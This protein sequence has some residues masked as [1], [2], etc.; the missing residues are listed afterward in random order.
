MVGSWVKATISADSTTIT[1]PLGQPIYYDAN[2][3]DTVVLGIMDLDEE[4]EE[5]FENTTVKE[6][7]YTVK[8]GKIS[9]N[10]TSRGRVLAALWKSTRAWAGQTDYN[11]Q[12]TLKTEAD[13]AVVAPEGLKTETYK[14][15]ARAYVGG[16]YVAYNVTVGFDGNDMYI[17]GLFSDTPDSWIKGTKNAAGSYVFT[18]GQ[19]LARTHTGTTNYYM[20]ATNHKDTK[21]IE[22][23]VLTYADSVKGYT[24][25]QYVVLNTAKK[26]V[27]LTEALD[28]VA[29]AKEMT[30]SAYA[31][32]YTE[33]FS[34]GLDDFTVIDVNG[35]GVTWRA[36]SGGVEYGF[37]YTKAADDWLISPK[38]KLEA[39]KYYKVTVRARSFTTSLPERM[40]VKMGSAATAE[41]MVSTVLPDTTAAT[42]D[43]K[44]FVGYVHPAADGKFNFGIYAT[45]PADNMMLAVSYFSVEETDEVTAGIK[46]AA[47][48]SADN[49]KLVATY[50][51]NGQ[52]VGANAK[53][54]LV[55]K[56]S[57]GTVSK[58][59][60]R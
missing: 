38:I 55:R 18:S 39:G 54:V 43:P 21:I 30:N 26:T 29:I 11:S 4:Y 6:V 13:T 57:D 23:L 20:I 50:N 60:V 14:L 58:V 10:G 40:E 17:K 42:E 1:L 49:R 22:D 8:D 25:D 53:G 44:D 59:V 5:F 12:Y 2:Q 33:N 15:R 31:V 45:S 9:L 16:N 24:T 36:H 32:P 46:S 34:G 19:Y 47:T 28:K 27:Y 56:Y 51:I 41:A 3:K 48:G 37:S 7:T 35:D 52:I